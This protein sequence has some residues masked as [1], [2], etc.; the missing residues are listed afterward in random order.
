VKIRYDAEVD[1]L[2][3]EL[4]PLEPGTAG[5]R[6]LSDDLI[7]DYGPDG[8]LADLELLDAAQVLGSVEGRIVLE[9]APS[10]LAATEAR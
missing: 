9:I 8:R 10:V 1:A 4:H 2:Y 6:Q 7:A 3:I 5:A